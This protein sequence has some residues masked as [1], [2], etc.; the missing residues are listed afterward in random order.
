MKGITVP[1]LLN[2]G[3][4][5]DTNATRAISV[6]A[7]LGHADGLRD[8]IDSRKSGSRLFPRCKAKSCQSMAFREASRASSTCWCGT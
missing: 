8:L 4:E 6:G 5:V 3:P 7:A 1:R 2:S